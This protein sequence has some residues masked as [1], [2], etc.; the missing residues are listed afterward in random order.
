MRTLD[1][2]H[3]LRR[4]AAPARRTG[5]EFVREAA[6][7]HDLPAAAIATAAPQVA[8]APGRSTASTSSRCSTA[9]RRPARRASALSSSAC[10]SPPPGS[11]AT[12]CGSTAAS[13]SRRS[14]AVGASRHRHPGRGS[15]HRRGC[16]VHRRGSR[17]RT[18]PAWSAR[19]AAATS[20]PTRCGWS[21]SPDDRA[22]GRLRPAAVVRSTSRSRSSA[23]RIRLPGRARPARRDR[24]AG[25]RIDYL[26]K[27]YAS[28]RRL[29]LDRLSAAGAGLARAQPR[30]LGVALVELLAYVG[31]HLSYQQDAVA[32]E[33]YLGTARRRVSVRRH[34]RLVDYRMHDGCNARAWVQLQVGT[35]AG[36]GPLLR[37]RDAAPHRATCPLRHRRIAAPG[38]A[39]S[40]EAALAQARGVRAA[41]RRTLFDRAQQDPSSTPGATSAAACR[42][43]ADPRDAS[44]RRPAPGD[45]SRRATSWSSRS[46]SARA[47]ATPATPIRRTATPCGSP[48]VRAV[49]RR[50][51]TASGAADGST[52]SPE[53]P[54]T[55]IALATRTTRCRSRCASPRHRPRLASVLLDGRQRR[56]A[57]TS[58]SPT[59]AA[60]IADERLGAV[61]R[62]TSSSLPTGCRCVRPA[63]AGPD[64][65]AVSS[66]PARAAADPG[67]RSTTC[68]NR[69]PPPPR[70]RTGAPAIVRAG[71]RARRRPR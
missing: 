11:A 50:C 31:D 13:G 64:P 44:R 63:R 19:D 38:V 10:S 30:R 37:R 15:G 32:T 33:A 61:P 59:T 62:R 7:S 18:S 47:T 48:R 36:G 22:A 16:R 56:A 58:C 2:A 17:P 71:H 8:R 35:G 25:A 34:A 57:A 28:F 52:P 41:A 69:R 20:R 45:R 43:G 40:V 68:R 55:E 53:Q 54:I 12:T 65:S 4:S 46:C 3:R 67:R 60:T 70:R 42:A 5:A 51:A 29:M 21:R 14:R 26:A 39:S 27:D 24:R 1:R 9:T 66:Q 6:R 23:R 49:R